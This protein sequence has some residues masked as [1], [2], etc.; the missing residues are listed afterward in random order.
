MN[1]EDT[2]LL[3]FGVLGVCYAVVVAVVIGN[4]R[5]AELRRTD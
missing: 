3:I 4:R 1:G 5:S 2:L